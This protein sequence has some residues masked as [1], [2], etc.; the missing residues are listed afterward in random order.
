MSWAKIEGIISV[1]PSTNKKGYIITALADQEELS[2]WTQNKD[3]FKVGDIVS[4]YFDD[5]WNKSKMEK[6]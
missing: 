3:D 5:K 2:A 1:V 6:A 4:T